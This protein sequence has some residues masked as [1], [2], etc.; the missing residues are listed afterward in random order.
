MGARGGRLAPKL[1]Q[2]RLGLSNDLVCRNHGSRK[3]SS[4]QV[5]GKKLSGTEIC[6]K[7]YVRI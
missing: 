1:L 7:I 3:V 2:S 5:P 4:L 6:G